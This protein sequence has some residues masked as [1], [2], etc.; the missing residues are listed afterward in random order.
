MDWRLGIPF[1][2]SC[3]DYRPAIC[4]LTKQNGYKNSFCL[5]PSALCL[6]N[7]SQLRS[8]EVPLLLQ[9][10]LKLLRLFSHG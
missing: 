9:R 7:S 8:G 1:P 6:P 2:L 3:Q 5:P 10:Q 4:S